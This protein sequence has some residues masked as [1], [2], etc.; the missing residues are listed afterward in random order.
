MG[1]FGDAAGAVVGAAGGAVFVADVVAGAD[2]L[3]CAVADHDGA[4]LDV[5][6]VVG[7]GD[8]L[9]AAIFIGVF[10]GD[11]AALLAQ[12]GGDFA[13]HVA[14]EV[15]GHFGFAGVG[16]VEGESTAEVVVADAGEVVVGVFDLGD[17]VFVP[18]NVNLSNFFPYHIHFFRCV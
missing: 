15:V 13:G 5:G 6:G 12:V 18:I 14:G 3:F 2:A 11:I 4:A 1:D 10:D 16:V 7:I 8:A 17:L 9:E